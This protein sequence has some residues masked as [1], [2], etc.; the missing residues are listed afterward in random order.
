LIRCDLVRAVEE[1]CYFYSEVSRC[2]RVAAAF[3]RRQRESLLSSS[4][5]EIGGGAKRRWPVAG[6]AY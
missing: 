1:E 3:F 4:S 5:P 6:G 2:M